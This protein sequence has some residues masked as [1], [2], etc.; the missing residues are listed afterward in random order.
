MYVDY[1]LTARDGLVIGTEGGYNSPV[2]PLYY[3]YMRIDN[4]GNM[5]TKATI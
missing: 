5:L 1:A 4:Q 2:N 3:A